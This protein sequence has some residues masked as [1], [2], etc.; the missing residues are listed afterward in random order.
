[1]VLEGRVLP[2]VAAADR[3][4]LAAIAVAVASSVGSPGHQSRQNFGSPLAQILQAVR[5]GKV[6]AVLDPCSSASQHQ[7]IDNRNYHP[8]C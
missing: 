8:E 5:P 1:M 3:T 2:E 7:R 4:V 6:D